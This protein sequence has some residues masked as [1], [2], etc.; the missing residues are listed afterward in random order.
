MNAGRAGA[1][2]G[3]PAATF[4]AGAPGPGR[5]QLLDR[6][7]AFLPVSEATPRISLGEGFTPLVHAERLGA[8]W[9]LDNLWL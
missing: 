2:A 9:G 5:Q 3:F 6:Y 4:A 7:R 8:A 1:A